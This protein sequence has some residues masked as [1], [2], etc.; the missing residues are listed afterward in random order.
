MFGFKN[1]IQGDF[2]KAKMQKTLG[3]IKTAPVFFTIFLTE[4]IS[5]FLDHHVIPQKL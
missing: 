5:K 3:K 2:F 1:M 4:I